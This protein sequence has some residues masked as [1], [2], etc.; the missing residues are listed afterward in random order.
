MIAVISSNV[1]AIGHDANTEELY[2]R[3]HHASRLY[4]YSGVSLSVYKQ[5]LQAPS[6]GRF[7]AFTVKKHYPFRQVA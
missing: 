6:K 3:F 2:V 7:L 1:A 4:V 5:F